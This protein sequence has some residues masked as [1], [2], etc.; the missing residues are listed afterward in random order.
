[1]AEWTANGVGH[2]PPPS[3]ELSALVD[4]GLAAAFTC[5]NLLIAISQRRIP[6]DMMFL[7]GDSRQ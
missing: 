1:M 7:C 2:D 6:F 5:S 4:G 3:G